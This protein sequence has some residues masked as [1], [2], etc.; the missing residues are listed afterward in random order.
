MGLNC[1]YG[2]FCVQFFFFFFLLKIFI[3]AKQ[4]TIL[5]GEFSGM[6]SNIGKKIFY[7]ETNPAF[8]S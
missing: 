8:I 2:K 1:L 7:I 5:F 3:W 6:Q 4:L